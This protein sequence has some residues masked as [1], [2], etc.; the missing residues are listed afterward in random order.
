MSL[1]EAFG[2]PAATHALAQMAPT[3]SLLVMMFLKLLKCILTDTIVSVL[4]VPS[5]VNSGPLFT[6]IPCKDFINT[7][8]NNLF[9]AK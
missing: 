6:F 9:P 7:Y 1:R 4:C 5:V 3:E 2:A 8:K